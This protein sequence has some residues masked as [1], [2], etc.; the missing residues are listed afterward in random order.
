[1][2]EKVLYDGSWTGFFTVVFEVYEYKINSAVIE[3]KDECNGSL[4]GNTHVTQTD[5]VKARRVIDKLGQR[6]TSKAFRQLYDNFLSE[7]KGVED[8]ML[9]YIRYILS[10]KVAVENNYANADVLALQQMSRKVHREKHHME[11]F[12]RFQ[13]TKDELYYA[14]VQPDYNV[15]PLILSHFKNRYADQRWLIYDSRRK[16]GI[17]YD[18]QQVTEVQLDF[19]ADLQNKNELS[20]IYDEKEDLYQTLWQQYFKSINIA[21]R[22]NMKLHIQHMP[23]RYWKYLVEK[24]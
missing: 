15:L 1:M 2:V 20:V 19:A 10:A 14:I 23:K 4:F 16:Y 12:V 3:K 5:A 11:A 17:Y 21:A 24:Q 13:L 6:L 22:K 18:L 9:R 7:E 8:T